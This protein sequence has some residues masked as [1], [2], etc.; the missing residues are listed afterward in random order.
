MLA[1]TN[2]KVVVEPTAQEATAF[3]AN[4]FKCIVCECVGKSGLCH[5]ALAGG[6]TP[7]ALYQEL[8]QAAATGELPWSAV[9]IFFGDE[10]D[11][12]HH[13]VES[14]YNMVQRTM[15]PPGPTGSRAST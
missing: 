4:L 9:D 11:V 13:H 12:P 1:D 10:R 14:N 7:H 6:T 8:T 15:L 2:A 3:V 5:V